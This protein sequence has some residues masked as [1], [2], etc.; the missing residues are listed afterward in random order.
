V[1]LF[2]RCAAAGG[3]LVLAVTL[4]GCGSSATNNTGGTGTAPDGSTTE[5][6]EVHNEADVDFAQGMI[7]HH[8]QAVEMSSLAMEQASS[9]DVR[10]LAEEISAAQGPEIETMTTFLQTWGE[11]VPDEM[12]DMGEMDMGD[13]SMSGLM[14]PEQMAQIE[15]AE[16]SEFDRLFL[17]MMT[18]HHQ[19]AVEMA[20][21][22][23]DEGENP[24]AIE[25]AEQIEAMQMEE[26]E[27]MQELLDSI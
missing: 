9:E 6:S 7:P 24:Q 10:Q 2:K 12:A 20:Q 5:V 23:Q 26:I 21:V 22:E 19:G 4:A 14:S 3:A 11:E 17:Q 13:M 16:G 25:L 1:T 18:E 15:A 8:R 27:R